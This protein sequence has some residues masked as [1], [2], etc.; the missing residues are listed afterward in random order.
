[1][2]A[3]I[4]PRVIAPTL[5]CPVRKQ[6]DTRVVLAEVHD[7][8]LEQKVVRAVLP[9]GS[10]LDLPYDTLVAAAGATH[11]CFGNDHRGRPRSGGRN[12]GQV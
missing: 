4:L 5:R 7:F 8:D 3:G 9:D 10:P 6:L 12:P 1:M 11:S 2:A